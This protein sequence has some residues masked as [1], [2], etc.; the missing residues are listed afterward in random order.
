MMDKFLQPCDYLP[1]IFL[2][3][4]DFLISVDFSTIDIFQ[5]IF[6]YRGK[7]PLEF[8]RERTPKIPLG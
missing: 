4:E 8:H 6:Q 2:I 1:I 7:S 5:K 3:A